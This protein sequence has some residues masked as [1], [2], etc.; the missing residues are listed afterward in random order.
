LIRSNACHGLGIGQCGL[1]LK[2]IDRDGDP[3]PIPLP[4]DAILDR[5]AVGL[6]MRI[7]RHIFHRHPTR[8][9]TLCLEIDERG[10]SINKYDQLRRRGSIGAESTG[11]I[12]RPYQEPIFTILRDSNG[13]SPLS[14][15]DPSLELPGPS[16][17]CGGM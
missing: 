6:N 3:Q 10:R 13:E 5:E 9:V 4:A 8:Q 7:G 14:G 15:W 12:Q 2:S 11:P 17:V 1:G 16:L